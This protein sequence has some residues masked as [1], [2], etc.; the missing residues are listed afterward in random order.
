MTLYCIR[1]ETQLT[2]T[3]ILSFL[4]IST[5]EIAALFTTIVITLCRAI[6]KIFRQ[7][8]FNF[9]VENYLHTW[10]LIP[11]LRALDWCQILSDSSSEFQ[12]VRHL[13]SPGSKFYLTIGTKLSHKTQWK[14]Y[15]QWH[16]LHRFWF[17]YFWCKIIKDALEFL[18]FNSNHILK[19]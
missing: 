4:T 9:Y 18:W 1:Q 3:P 19:I 16:L 7:Y 5:F 13:S 17:R 8:N 10:K 15:Q 2:Q 6:T 14:W 11:I 12:L